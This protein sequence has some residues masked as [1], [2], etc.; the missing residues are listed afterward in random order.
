VVPG[1]DVVHLQNTDH[2][3]TVWMGHGNQP[4][5]GDVTMALLELALKK[6]SDQEAAAKGSH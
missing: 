1:S 6:A 4:S 2:L 5:P 3:D